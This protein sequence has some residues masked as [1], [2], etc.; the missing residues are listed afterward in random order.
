MTTKS[1]N[2]KAL[3]NAHRITLKKQ[4]DLGKIQKIIGGFMNCDVAIRDP[5]SLNVIENLGKDKFD[6]AI[7]TDLHIKPDSPMNP[8][9]YQQVNSV[10]KTITILVQNAVKDIINKS[11]ETKKEQLRNVLLNYITYQF[12]N[13][14]WE[15]DKY[16]QRSKQSIESILYKHPGNV[17][18]TQ[19]DKLFPTNAI[20]IYFKE[21]DNKDIIKLFFMDCFKKN[22]IEN[23]VSSLF[24][25]GQ[26]ENNIVSIINNNIEIAAP[27]VVPKLI[28]DYEKIHKYTKSQI[29]DRLS[30][31][32]VSVS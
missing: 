6:K 14:K 32:Q 1:A 17:S 13:I 19:P 25:S 9:I 5:E 23:S 11:L 12:Y 30:K 3:K 8:Y 31:T 2:K 10:V 7:E 4:K 18:K 27:Y 15:D 28:S 16:Y 22:N 26:G 20:D 29:Q 24:E 21:L